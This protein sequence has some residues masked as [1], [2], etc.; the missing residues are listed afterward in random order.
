MTSSVSFKMFHTKNQDQSETV[1]F[2]GH[3]IQLLNFK[4]EVL[5]RKKMSGSLDFDLKITDESGKGF[6]IYF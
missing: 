1:L 4:K 2:P 5:E 3:S 6:D